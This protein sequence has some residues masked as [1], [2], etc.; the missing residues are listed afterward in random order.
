MGIENLKINKQG[1]T[2]L[3]LVMVVAILGI[4]STLALPLYTTA[5]ERVHARDAEQ[6]LVAFFEAEK[7]YAIENG[8]QYTRNLSALDIGITAPQKFSLISAWDDNP[9]VYLTVDGVSQPDR[10]QILR[11]SD[12]GLTILYCLSILENGQVVCIGTNIC[13]K[14]GYKPV[15]GSS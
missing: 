12:D 11:M 4:L 13:N 9:T 7:K 10:G 8:G 14:L 6:I 1:Y 3:E 15:D 5:I 2:V